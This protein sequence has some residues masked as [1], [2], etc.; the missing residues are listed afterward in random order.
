MGDDRI[1]Q[2][3][4]QRIGEPLN[5]A[6]QN[7]APLLVCRDDNAVAHERTDELRL[8]DVHSMGNGAQD[9]VTAVGVV[10]KSNG[11]GSDHTAERRLRGG[12]AK[13]LHEALQRV[14][15]GLRTGDLHERVSR[16]KGVEQLPVALLAKRLDQL[17]NEQ[18]AVRLRGQRSDF[19]QGGG[20]HAG[21]FV[22]ARVVKMNLGRGAALLRDG[23]IDELESFTVQP[24]SDAE[25]A[26]DFCLL[27]VEGRQLFV[28]LLATSADFFEALHDELNLTAS[29][30]AARKL[31]VDAEAKSGVVCVQHRRGHGSK[32]C[33]RRVQQTGVPRGVALQ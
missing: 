31:K 32:P 10:R 30:V 12:I 8:V 1:H 14:S 27:G 33:P 4:T 11:A 22:L 26:A 3:V 19:T 17:L 13:D 6:L 25:L 2:L 28:E 15:A 18:S 20:E 16:V 29:R 24:A 9:H 21:T 23:L 5:G 7:A